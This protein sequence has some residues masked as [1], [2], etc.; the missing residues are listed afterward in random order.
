MR[1]GML[2]MPN[3]RARAARRAGHAISCAGMPTSGYRRRPPAVAVPKKAPLG[4]LSR[5]LG[6]GDLACAS[7][8]KRAAGRALRES[9]GLQSGSGG[10]QSISRSERLR[11]PCQGPARQPQ[12]FF[13]RGRVLFRCWQSVSN[14]HGI[15]ARL[16]RHPRRVLVGGVGL[17]PKPEPRRA[18]PRSGRWPAS[19]VSRVRLQRAARRQLSS[20]AGSR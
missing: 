3:P 7:I 5:T 17:D 10:E 11:M 12:Q 16:A 19:E 9:P 2:R 1:V 14:W 6:L 13:A 4:G 20:Y 18:S 8:P 15:R